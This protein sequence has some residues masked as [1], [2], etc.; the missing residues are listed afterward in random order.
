MP[1]VKFGGLKETTVKNVALIK[2]YINNDA[3]YVKIYR[4]YNFLLLNRFFA[5]FYG[6]YMCFN[7]LS[8]EEEKKLPPMALNLIPHATPFNTSNK[9]A[10]LSH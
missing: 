1:I 8:A 7:S 4:V 2:L 10:F 3:S 9:L 6:T 5:I